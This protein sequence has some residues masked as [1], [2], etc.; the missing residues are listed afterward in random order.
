M[1]E[2]LFLNLNTNL[3]NTDPVTLQGLLQPGLCHY[4]IL[5][6]IIFITGIV[7]VILSGNLIKTLIGLQFMLNAVCLN[8]AAANA[9]LT[10]KNSP[11]SLANATAGL[12]QNTIANSF[13]PVQNLH[14]TFQAPEGQAAALI[15]AITGLINTAVFFGIICALFFKFKN[16][17]TTSLCTLKSADCPT[18]KNLENEGGL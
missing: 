11:A 15:I 13:A 12:V 14:F 4:L 1:F 5:G 7:I 9:F 10:D 17:Y 3:Q 8:F 2:E 16:T 18:D 6:I